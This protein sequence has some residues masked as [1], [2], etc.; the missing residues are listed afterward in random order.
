MSEIETFAE[1]K[2]SQKDDIAQL[3]KGG[4]RDRRLASLLARCRKGNRCNLVKCPVCERR[5]ERAGTQIGRASATKSVIGSLRARIFLPYVEVVGKRRP[6]NEAKVRFLAASMREIGQQS[7]ITVRE[8]GKKVIL[9]AGLYRLAAAK[10]LG[11]DSILCHYMVGGKIDARLWQISEN[12]HR[13]DLRVLERSEYIEEWRLLIRKKA[14]VG[15]VAPPG[16]HQPKDAGIN[17][18]AKELGLTKEEIRRAKI[19]AGISPKAK[20][21]AIAA[22]LDNSQRALLEIAKQ[23]TPS[24]QL[25]A[26]EKIV[27]R[28]RVER[29][30]HASDA[31][32]EATAE[33]AKLKAD[34]AKNEGALE[35]LK[36]KIVDKRKR[37][38]QLKG[39]SAADYAS[40]TIPITSPSTS[41]THEVNDIVSPS[42][43]P[44]QDGGDDLDIPESLDRRPLSV[45]DEE[46][47]GALRDAWYGALDV[48]IAWAKASNVVRERFIADDLRAST[49][50]I[51]STE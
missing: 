10:L 38:G 31:K 45:V 22:K 35:S 48:R 23:P 36:A 7:P 28:K 13:A 50:S 33:I 21:A 1:A 40:A 47:L 15:Q 26:I 20:V 32:K 39:A 3:K 49:S 17:K 6:L 24:A 27:E 44:A 12:L 16:G 30:R 41:P 8:V 2:Q 18:A 11:W 51:S 19:I 9:V 34:I 25:K 42:S 46:F 14:Q 37:L 29:I 5:K 43:V 4:K